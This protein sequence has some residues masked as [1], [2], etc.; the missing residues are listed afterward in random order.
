[1][2]LIIGNLL[3][4]HI[5]VPDYLRTCSLAAAYYKWM[6]RYVVPRLPAWRLTPNRVSWIGMLVS[7]AV[8]LGFRAH[9][10][11]GFVLILFSSV[12]DSLDGLM[13]RQQNS[14]S[15]WGAFL[16]SNLDRISDFFY[17]LGFWV[18]L[19]RT[20]GP[21]AAG[22]SVFTCIL[23]TMMISYTKARAEG[24][25]CPCPVGLMERGLRVIYLMLWALALILLPSHTTSV[26][27]MGLTLY[28]ALTLATVIQRIIY[29]RH[30]LQGPD[31]GS[32]PVGPRD[33]GSRPI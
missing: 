3:G 17:L 6:Q 13:A 18:L 8:P 16:D 9:P 7:M 20:A 32:T 28:G 2:L 25:G 4:G 11:W 14:S 29:I 10:F 5:L 27:W 26:L 12:A 24:L 31:A 33:H 1:M 15:R 21:T 23:L 22:L 30:R 19:S